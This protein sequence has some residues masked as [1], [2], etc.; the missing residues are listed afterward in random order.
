MSAAL[1]F[2]EHKTRSDRDECSKN[3]G[4]VYECVSSGQND[5]AKR[6]SL[7]TEEGLSDLED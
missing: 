4:R 7:Y 5:L 6:A 1:S 3:V 2:L